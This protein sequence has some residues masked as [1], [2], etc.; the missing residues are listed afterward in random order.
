MHTVSLGRDWSPPN[1]T[2]YF[3]CYHG[4]CFYLKGEG[5]GYLFV[6]V[7]P[8]FVG[9]GPR[10]KICWGVFFFWGCGR[11]CIIYWNQVVFVYYSSVS[12]S[13]VFFHVAQG[14]GGVGFIR[15]LFTYV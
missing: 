9:I 11:F 13:L 1:P 5:K 3:H 12:V 14:L 4:S 6:L 8:F 15:R 10:P 7:M 2:C